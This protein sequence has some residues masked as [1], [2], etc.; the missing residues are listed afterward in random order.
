MQDTTQLA[1][2]V[3]ATTAV[4]LTLLTGL[5]SL[6]GNL[7][8]QATDAMQA[9]IVAPECPAIPPKEKTE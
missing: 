9:T 1:T 7:M 2:L 5:H 3:A 8:N 6:S 4:A